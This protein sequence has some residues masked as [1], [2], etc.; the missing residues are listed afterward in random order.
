M[1]PSEPRIFSG[2]SN[3]EFAVKMCKYLGITEGQG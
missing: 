3:P 1:N 2:R